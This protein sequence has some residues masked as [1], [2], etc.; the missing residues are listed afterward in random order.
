MTKYTILMPDRISGVAEIENEVFGGVGRVVTANATH[1]DQ[2][3]D[4]TWASA[5]AIL[6]W[7]DLAYDA[8][9]IEKLVRCRVI[10]RVGAGFD[11][12]DLAAAARRGIAVCN[13]PDY[14]TNDVAD[15]AIA[16]MLSLA[17]GV[18]AYDARAR[19]VV[20][21]WRWDSAAGLRRI[22]GSTF[23]VI[24]LGRIGTAAARRAAAFGMRVGFYDPYLADGMDKALG[25]ERFD[26]LAALLAAADVISFHLPLTPDT[27]GLANREFFAQMKPGA[28][29]INTARGPVVDLD[30]LTNA[31]QIGQLRGAGLDVLPEEPPSSDH[32]LIR[33][34][35]AREPWIEG[36][37]VITPHA[38]F[39]CAESYA[40]M[41]RKAA[42]TALQA[43]QGQT[44]RNC[45]NLR[46]LAAVQ[47]T[48]NGG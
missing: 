44:S 10:V 29:L 22:A 28:L 42:V 12:V 4:A 6:A 13:V 7:H 26:S 5:D 3:D 33:A 18:V 14:G 2:I 35:Q 21:G 25:V 41:R 36:R 1:A 24:G 31:L 17:R 16:L 27:R 37:L 30:A 11:N 32:P 43:L 23:G 45:V 34:W 15:H 9:L 19:E 20:G 39:Y 47:S 40:E 48:V 8:R 46:E 38:A